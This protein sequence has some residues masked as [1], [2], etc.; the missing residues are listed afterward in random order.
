MS[1]S[2]AILVFVA[3]ASSSLSW[4]PAPSAADMGYR[5]VATSTRYGPS[6]FTS[7]DM[8]SG[9]LVEGTD[10]LA[11]ASAQ[12]MQNLF[13]GGEGACVPGQ[14]RCGRAGPGTGGDTV[15]AMGCGTCARGRFFRQLPRGYKVW[16]P[17]DAA[18]FHTE[19]KVVVVDIC[20]NFEN[21]LWCPATPSDTNEFG[22]HNHFDFATFPELFD[23]FYFAFTP[24][25]CDEEMKVRNDRRVSRR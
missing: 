17:P 6:K 8:D 22:V 25:P 7:C 2:L 19:Y 20:P 18:I 13:P 11:V 4:P 5:Y 24:E 10:Y 9:A 14:C 3:R 23:N 12:A 15:A 16:T 1:T 21:S